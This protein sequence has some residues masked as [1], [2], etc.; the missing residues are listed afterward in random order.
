MNL[1]CLLWTGVSGWQQTDS[2]F[3][4]R[5]C[6]RT[7]LTLQRVHLPSHSASTHHAVPSS[8]SSWIKFT[9][10]WLITSSQTPLIPPWR[11]IISSPVSTFSCLKLPISSSIITNLTCPL[12][13]AV[14]DSFCQDVHKMQLKAFS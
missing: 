7:V 4:G 13:C 5:T 14:R 10:L 3:F 8:S 9:F 11:F 12:P 1:S 2:S 6:D